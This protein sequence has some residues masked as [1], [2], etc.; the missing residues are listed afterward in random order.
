MSNEE[1]YNP[2]ALIIK[3]PSPRQPVPCKLSPTFNLAYASFCSQV[4][5]RLQQEETVVDV[6]II[7]ICLKL[8]VDIAIQVAIAIYNETNHRDEKVQALSKRLVC[9]YY[10]EHVTKIQQDMHININ[11]AFSHYQ[12]SVDP[13]FLYHQPHVPTVKPQKHASCC[14]LS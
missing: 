2:W 5:F 9:Q 4:D 10:E 6:A 3:S 7:G 13:T 11:H 12:P 1:E 14:L 8:L